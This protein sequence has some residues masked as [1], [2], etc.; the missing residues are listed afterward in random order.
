[1][2]KLV[3]KDLPCQVGDTL[4][5]VLMWQRLNAGVLA[6]CPERWS[7]L[8]DNQKWVTIRILARR[9]GYTPDWISSDLWASL[10]SQLIYV[11][12][13]EETDLLEMGHTGV[14]AGS[15][16]RRSYRAPGE[17]VTA[18]QAT[19]LDFVQS[20]RGAPQHIAEDLV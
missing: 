8:T 1:M 19:A 13:D 16:D 11:G 12:F 14:Y 20:L 3:L 2:T 7:D 6:L 10:K 4:Y 18:E 9:D 17:V 5:T 15:A